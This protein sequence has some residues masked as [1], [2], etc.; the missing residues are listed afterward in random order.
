MFTG[1]VAD[2]ASQYS[3]PVIA[4]T[5]TD[6]FIESRSKR[7]TLIRLLPSD[8]YQSRAVFDI[9][10]RYEWKQF[11]ILTS[12][13][14]Y[15]ING[16]LELQ[17]L[18]TNNHIKILNIQ[19]FQLPVGGKEPNVY[20][21]LSIIKNSMARVIV[22][23]CHAK[24]SFSIFKQAHRMGMLDKGFVWILTEG[25]TGAHHFLA[26]EFGNF[27]RYYEGL[28]GTRPV[29]E[30]EKIYDSF[31]ERYVANFKRPDDLTPFTKL[32]YDSVWVM[33]HAIQN[34][35]SSGYK[36]YEKK[37]DCTFGPQGENQVGQSNHWENGTLLTQQIK[38]I[39][40]D[41]ITSKIEFGINGEPH[42]KMYDVVNFRG[43]SFINVGRWTNQT[44]L[45]IGSEVQFLG[46]TFEP[47]ND[48]PK[49]LNGRHLVL[50]ILEEHPFIIK[51]NNCKSDI[52]CYE[53]YCIDLIKNLSVDLNFTY[54]FK[55]P[56][57]H[58]WGGYDNLTESWNGLVKMLIDKKIDIASVHLSINSL[59]ERYIDFSV[60]FMDAGLLVVVRGETHNHA[61]KFF[62]LSP[63]S[64]EVWYSI[65]L[66][67]LLV[68]VSLC[69][70]NKVSPYG[71]YGAKMFAL[72][73]CRCRKCKLNRSLSLD[74]CRGHRK[75]LKP[76]CMVDR[77]EKGSKDILDQLSLY[78]SS[79]FVTAALLSQSPVEPGPHCAS[80]RFLVM[81][82]WFFMMIVLAMYTAN[83]A[84]F[85]TVNRLQVGLQQVDDLLRQSEY[86][87]GTVFSTNP[88]ILMRN[89]LKLSYQEI[90]QRAI[91]VENAKEGFEK[92][93]MGKFAFIYESPFLEYNLRLSCEMTKI[94]EKFNKFGLAFG[95]QQNAPYAEV[96]NHMLLKYRELG[97]LDLLWKKWLNTKI[98]CPG[99]MR[100]STL[101]MTYLSGLFL[102]LGAAVL[103]T[104]IVVLIELIIA[105]VLD[106]YGNG[107]RPLD[108]KGKE[109]RSIKLAFKRRINVLRHDLFCH[110][111]SFD[112]FKSSN[113]TDSHISSV[114]ME[115]DENIPTLQDIMMY[116]VTST[117]DK[118][119]NHELL[120]S[121]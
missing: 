30:N 67:C 84:A 97:R 36:L 80:G 99:S 89:S 75:V 83:L 86:Q 22:L 119:V 6:P 23:N 57:D 104:L 60:P 33:A 117:T 63:F 121:T 45:T 73:S 111:F 107:I 100:G 5:A 115:S 105:T 55:V 68:T 17:W 19:H 65:I 52:D 92:A 114:N 15:G 94:G 93:K 14:P 74:K 113:G 106:A 98:Q 59:R 13:D 18:A 108:E 69:L 16:V 61:D 72:M 112:S 42:V 21:E 35:V 12:Y 7:K 44:G 90:I 51:K 103:V 102:F 2:T 24:G 120:D 29:A 34:Y 31:A 96:I 28:I 71:K 40:F 81:A 39:V 95:M 41:G 56:M 70:A 10:R 46:R 48:V 64:N 66:A 101:D 3:I 50:G 27:P 49:T 43:G 110:W 4:P 26:D 109:C 54:E 78:N 58:M 53:G 82:W 79:W 88:E 11:S 37:I 47:P 62:F 76:E 38:Q 9:I 20:S 91:P 116:P 77:T 8:V 25:I 87:W 85:L 1:M 118:H 32:V